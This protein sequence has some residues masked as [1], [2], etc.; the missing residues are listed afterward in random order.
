MRGRSE[1]RLRSIG[2]AEKREA[3]DER[4]SE[5]KEKRNE[6]NKIKQKKSSGSKNELGVRS[7]GRHKKVR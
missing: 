5:K 3:I 2:I 6:T 7:N 1:G 4:G